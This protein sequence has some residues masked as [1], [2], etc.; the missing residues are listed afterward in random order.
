MQFHSP[1]GWLDCSRRILLVA[2]HP[3]DEVLS[4]GAHFRSLHPRLFHLTSGGSSSTAGQ[5]LAKIRFLELDRAL[6]IGRIPTRH[7][8]SCGV[9]DQQ[10]IDFLPT[11]FS[12]LREVV[13]RIKPSCL[14]SHPYEGGHPDHDAAALVC[15]LVASSFNAMPIFEFPSYHNGTPFA[16]TASWKTASF[17]E[18]TS[19]QISIRLTG[20]QQKLK[21]R[22]LAAFQSQAAV[23]KLFPVSVEKFRPA[24][25][26]NFLEPPHRGHLL[27]DAFGWDTY[28][29]WRRRA[30]A[31][32]SSIGIDSAESMQRLKSI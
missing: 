27:Y 22:M 21:K 9:A 7:R 23:L 16:Q 11:I 18:P 30:C 10:V 24:P 5:R 13:E 4:L 15:N 17:L 19:E 32:M 12:K 6:K 8:F 25:A 31:A 2:A 26:Y 3:D 1:E 28:P 29:A 20:K 14:L